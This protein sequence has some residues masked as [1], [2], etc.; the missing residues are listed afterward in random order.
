MKKKIFIG[1]FLF[2]LFTAPSF[3]QLILPIKKIHAYKQATI[4]GIPQTSFDENGNKIIAS[5]KPTFNYWIYVEFQKSEK[6]EIVDLWISGIRFKAKSETI[7]SLP[8]KKIIYTANSG[9]DTVLLMPPTSQNVLLT[10]PIDLLNKNSNSST[11]L[12]K[13][14]KQSE[15][16]IGFYWNGKKYFA[17]TK[18]IKLLE[19]DAHL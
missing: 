1:C 8:V 12:N 16:V 19:P 2:C 4:P 14:I 13:L 7:N 11:Y 9:N 17:S 3:S 18:Q 6:I 15:L 5:R 10:Y